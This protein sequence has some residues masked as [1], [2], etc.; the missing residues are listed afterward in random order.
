MTRGTPVIEVRGIRKAYGR[1]IAVDDVSFDVDQ[2]S[3]RRVI[4][5]LPD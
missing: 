5:S 1:T 3:K 4:D 2:L